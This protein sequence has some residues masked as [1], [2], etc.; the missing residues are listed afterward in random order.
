VKAGGGREE[1]LA[2][3]MSPEEIKAWAARIAAE[4]RGE[5]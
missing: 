5:K 1:K 3:E 4:A 2:S